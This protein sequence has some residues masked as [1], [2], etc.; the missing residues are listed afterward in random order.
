MKEAIKLRKELTD[1]GIALKKGDF[2]SSKFSI[3]GQDLDLDTISVGRALQLAKSNETRLLS[4]N[5]QKVKAPKEA[6][7]PQASGKP[8]GK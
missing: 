4:F 8:A 7:E 6:A 5:D 2:Y 1:A 3:G